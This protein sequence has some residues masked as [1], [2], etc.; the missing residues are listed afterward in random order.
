MKK[1]YILLWL[2]FIMASLNAQ[3]L[4]IKSKETQKPLSG[5]V[6]LQEHPLISI[7]TDKNGEAS[8]VNFDLTRNIDIYLE[9]YQSV[10][11]SYHK[12]KEGQTFIVYLETQSLKLSE[13]IISATRWHESTK[14]IPMQT[15]SIHSK[16]ISLGQA[17]TAAD[18]LDLSG[19]VFIQKSQQGGGSPMIRGFAANRLIYT[20]DGVRMN[21]AIFR[22]GNIQNV[23]NLDPFTIEQTEVIFGPGSVIYGSDAIGGVMSFQTLKPQLSTQNEIKV[24]GNANLRYSSA[25]QEKTAHFD[26]KLGTQKWAFVSSYS[27]W[28]FDHLR[29]GSYGPQDYLK[30]RY[31][32]RIDTQ[33]VVILQNNPLL[34]IPSGYTQDNFMQKILFK[35]NDKW[36]FQYGLHY[37]R[38]SN[39][40][41]YDRLS[42]MR[43]GQFRHAEWDYGPQLWSMHTLQINHHSYNPWYDQ[44]S[45]RI[46]LQ[47]FGESRITRDFQS[48]QRYIQS[49]QVDAYSLNADFSKSIGAKNTLFYGIE[50]VYNLVE[51]KGKSVMILAGSEQLAASRYPNAL[52]NS[53]GIYANDEQELGEKTTLRTGIR[54]NILGLNARFDNNATFFPL[55]FETA[56][57]QNNALTG[58][59]GLVH[60]ISSNSLIRANLGTAFRSPNVDDLGK[61]FDNEPGS[62]TIPNS[63]L[64][65]EY[66]YNADFGIAHVSKDLWKFEMS[67]F[68]TYLDNAMVRRDF[69][70]LGVD[71]IDYQGNKAKI[72]AIQNA[73]FAQVYGIHAG[74]ELKLY[75]QLHWR[76]DFNYQWGHE[77][78]EQG[79]ISPSRHVAPLFGL[80]RIRFQTEGTTLEFNVRFQGERGHALLAFEERN[81]DEIYAKDANGKNYA[82]AWFTLNFRILKQIY[83]A[84]HIAA[85]IENLS[86]TRY[87]SYSSGISGAGRNVYCSLN[88][89]F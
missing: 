85:G 47:H 1:Q 72:Q 13:I 87:R 29:Q 81:K 75:R 11:I 67:G 71:S 88:W 37:S 59:I 5:V 64:S 56:Q 44:M 23:I 3:N 17:Q 63:Q 83:E 60:R 46:A 41:R 51:S 78:T 4:Y 69:S 38:T 15:A 39:F 58:S 43:R 57:L 7:F 19:K 40:G 12:P 14:N 32:Q 34:Q 73:A 33:D 10:K 80:S 28:D 21:N 27:H 22:S 77:E 26:L 54:Y 8:L 24:S 89:K 68:F 66:A 50:G 84:C 18:L 55:P 16:E 52:W 49:E 86:D 9:G 6:L 30:N 79:E 61:F 74:L 20:I 25:N 36:D 31:V 2:M 35:P 70:L 82:P 76:T 65:S 48:T 53:F 62:V 42:R 45:I